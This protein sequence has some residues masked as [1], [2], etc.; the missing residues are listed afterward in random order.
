MQQPR[1]LLDALGLLLDRRAAF[2]DLLDAVALGQRPV[3]VLEV[4]EEVLRLG[5]LVSVG[6]PEVA[7]EALLAAGPKHRG[8]V[9]RTDEPLLAVLLD[10]PPRARD[11]RPQLVHSP[12]GDS[13]LEPE[14]TGELEEAPRRVDLLGPRRP[15]DRVEEVRVEVDPAAPELFL[16]QL[17]RR[18]VDRQDRHV[19]AG[20]Q[21]VREVLSL[22]RGGGADEGRQSA[23]AEGGQLVRPLGQRLERTTVDGVEE[24]TSALLLGIEHH[25]R[26]GAVAC[27]DR[28]KPLPKIGSQRGHVLIG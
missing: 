7:V 16:H 26:L 11:A 8:R 25:R 21:E 3:E 4:V 9:L 15:E 23:L 12:R 28:L 18:R 17:P 1:V 2:A 13:E 27:D 22:V 6:L 14:A 5:L 19:E 24:P 10:L 20:V